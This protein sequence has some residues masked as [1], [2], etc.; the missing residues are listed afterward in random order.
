LC[1]A[2]PASAFSP[3]VSFFL[4][5]SSLSSPQKI[6]FRSSVL[7]PLLFIPAGLVGAEGNPVKPV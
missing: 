4:Q 1:F 5:L 7:F 6:E 2:L 3:P